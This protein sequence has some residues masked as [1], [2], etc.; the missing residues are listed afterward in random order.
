MLFLLHLDRLWSAPIKMVVPSTN[1]SCSLDFEETL[2]GG[3]VGWVFFCSYML[4]LTRRAGVSYLLYSVGHEHME[5][6]RIVPYVAQ[7]QLTVSPEHLLYVF[8]SRVLAAGLN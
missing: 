8:C 6:S 3:F 7:D 4:P 1:E 5:A 2:H